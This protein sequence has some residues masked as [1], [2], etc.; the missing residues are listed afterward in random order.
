[1]AETKIKG[2][3]LNFITGINGLIEAPALKVYTLIQSMP[4]AAVLSRLTAKSTNASANGTLVIKIND[5]AVTFAGG[6]FDITDDTE[7]T[8]TISAGGSVAVG[9]T[10]ALEVTAQSGSLDDLS[11]T[12]EYDR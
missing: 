7:V 10:V 3:Q 12:L 2:P 5:V 9:G 11:F 1:M 4:F 8:D 6:D